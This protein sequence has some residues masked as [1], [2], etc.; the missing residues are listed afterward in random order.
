MGAPEIVLEGCPGDTGT[1]T[2]ADELWADSG[3]M[4]LTGRADEE[5]VVIDAPVASHMVAAAR[6]LEDACGVVVD[7]PALLGER[8]AIAG[9][10]RRGMTSV[11]GAASMQRSADGWVVL[12][13]ARRDDV[14]ALP[15]LVQRRI[16]PQDWLGVRA[17]IASE[18][19]GE[20]IE[21]GAALGLAVAGVAERTEPALTAWEI[22]GWSHVSVVPERPLVLDCSALWAGPL[23][24]DLLARSGCRVIKIEHPRR[25]DGARN[26][27][28]DF[29]DL[30]NG[31]KESVALDLDLATD[32][33][34]FTSLLD[35]ASVV[36]EGSRPRFFDRLGIDRAD[37]VRRGTIWLTVSA[38][39]FEEPHKN[40]AGF[41]DDAASAVGLVAWDGDQPLFAA[42][43][44]ADPIAGLFGAVAVAELLKGQ[45]S[46]QI[47]LSLAGAAANCTQPLA[48]GLTEGQRSELVARRP[49]ARRIERRAVELS[50]HTEVIRQEFL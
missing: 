47:D 17:A 6:R 9:L 34:L 16:D 4:W 27:P 20:L 33:R 12:N 44:I 41:G 19:S 24:A 22:V 10:A 43:A 14:E 30:M 40:R 39:G 37:R 29:F 2:E 31:H 3:A 36:I 38:H 1:V 32:L 13:L 25:P 8:A 21:R 15:A 5:P 45:R 50:A 11:G 7:G 48:G 23:C 18:S 49:R 46:S 28:A 35:V 26:G 42:D